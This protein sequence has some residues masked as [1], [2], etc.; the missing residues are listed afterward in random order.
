MSGNS[1]NAAR[2]KPRTPSKDHVLRKRPPQKLQTGKTDIYVSSK[3][4][5]KVCTCLNF[6]NEVRQERF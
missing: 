6:K 2:K 3:S 4:D 5:T 1:E